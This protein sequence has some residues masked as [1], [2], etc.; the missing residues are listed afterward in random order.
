MKNETKLPPVGNKA[1][2]NFPIER[3]LWNMFK[4]MCHQ[5]GEAAA[6]RLRRLIREDLKSSDPNQK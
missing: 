2:V 5:N 4:E 6:A 3:E 1:A